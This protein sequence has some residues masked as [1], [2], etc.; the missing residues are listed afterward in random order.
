MTAKEKSEMR[1]LMREVIRDEVSDIVRDI[2]QEE[3][4][5]LRPDIVPLAKAAELYG[6]KPSTL[7]KLGKTLGAIRAGGKIFFSCR[8]IDGAILAGLI[9]PINRKTEEK[10]SGNP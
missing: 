6:W 5:R 8:A 1:R 9:K 4:D 7:Y 3:V 10:Y 2:M